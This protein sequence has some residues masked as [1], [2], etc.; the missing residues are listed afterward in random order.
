MTGSAMAVPFNTRPIAATTGDLDGYTGSLQDIFDTIGSSIDVYNDQSGAAI[1]QP[2]SAGTSATYITS[3]SWGAY[4]GSYEI[5]LYQYGD[6]STNVKLF[7]ED[8]SA[9][10]VSINF[11]ASGTV[12]TSYF[13]EA[14]SAWET[15]DVQTDFGNTFGFYLTS[16]Y[17]TW[18]SEDDLN[19]TGQAQM[20]MYEAKGDPVEIN[21]QHFTTDEDHW[22][23]AMEGADQLDW[24]Y[25][26]G[27]IDYNDFVL[28]VESVQPVPEPA[29]MLLLGS[30]LIGLA[31]MGRKKFFKK[32]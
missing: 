12:A 15:V 22:Y 28:Q 4:S 2:T 8:I 1:F 13:N 31:G 23:V 26:S 18:Y 32:S 16:T 21:G 5:G 14:A 10:N 27:N 17:G 25:G 19:G 6:T 11:A 24:P 7:D 30:G 29:T 9:G 20:L 3:M